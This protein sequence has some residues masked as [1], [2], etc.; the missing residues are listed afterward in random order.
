[1]S[2]VHWSTPSGKHN[3]N[4]TGI[5]AARA[6]AEARQREKDRVRRELTGLMPSQLSRLSKRSQYE[7]PA[8]DLSS[9]SPVRLAK[10]GAEADHSHGGQG[11]QSPRY[12]QAP[13]HKR[14]DLA[15]RPTVCGSKHSPHLSSSAG[16]VSS[17]IQLTIDTSDRRERTI[18]PRSGGPSDSTLVLAAVDNARSD[19]LTPKPCKARSEGSSLSLCQQSGSSAMNEST[20]QF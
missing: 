11:Q 17:R 20:E 12:G 4:A 18:E 1:M 10:E 16:A 6:Y 9:C 14:S 5:G 15:L 13:S 3:L 19:L 8:L 7:I 2:A